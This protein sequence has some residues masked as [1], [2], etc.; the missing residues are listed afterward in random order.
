MFGNLGGIGTL[1][2]SGL[3][4]VTPTSSNYTLR[5][6]EFGGGG[7][8]GSS[9]TYKLNSV[10]GTQTGAPNSSTNYTDKSGLAQVTNSNVP[11]APT[12]TNP[13]NFY[14]RLQLVIGTG[15]NPSDTKFAVAISSDNFT[16]TR[17]V[18]SDNSTG[19]TL[20]ATD[21]R[22]YASWG[23]ASGIQI[24]G[25]LSNTTYTVKVK[26]MQ[27]SF[28]ETTYGPTTS[29]ATAQ[30]S[31]TFGVATTADPTPPFSLAFPSLALG[32]VFNAD[33]DASISLS[34][35]AL[36]GATIYVTD[37]NAGL[38][39]T[40]AAYTL[41]SA[42]ADLS[43][44]ARGYGAIV[45]ATSQ[46]SGGPFTVSA[47]FN[48]AGNNVGALSTS[49][50]KLASTVATVTGGSVTVQLKAKTDTTVPS[51]TDYSDALTFVVS[52]VF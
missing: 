46:S 15:S 4:A 39:S 17:Y 21:Y 42:S 1:L 19:A 49:L 25:L 2:L 22:T 43:S 6:F 41:T 34:T 3:F 26:A 27:G 14:D 12:L 8:S 16:T 45:T 50:Q 32:T 30:P 52:A 33:A 36:S 11:P 28:T 40:R 20:V 35:N 38:H 24:L 13:S 29:V 7:G 9:A 18:K 31:V 23:S 37:T 47:P 48:G 10:T 44:V 5:N 51:E